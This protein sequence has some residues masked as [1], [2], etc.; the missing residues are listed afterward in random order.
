MGGVPRLCEARGA[1]G[2]RWQLETLPQLAPMDGSQT[3]I[4]ALFDLLGEG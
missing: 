4:L 3:V 2:A 1:A